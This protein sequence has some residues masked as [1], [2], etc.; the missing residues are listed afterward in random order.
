M[1]QIDLD[2]L[3]SRIYVNEIRAQS[4]ATVA[5]ADAT[6][7]NITVVNLK[8]DVTVPA[9]N[10]ITVEDAAGLAIAGEPL[11]DVVATTSKHWEDKSAAF[12]AVAGTSYICD[13]TSSAF[14]VTLPLEPT[15]GD[16]I[17][18]L[19]A[20]GTFDSNNLTLLGNGEKI[21]RVAS[22]DMAIDED[23]TYLEMI[24]TGTTNGWLVGSTN[25]VL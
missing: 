15:Y 25:L 17:A 9:G 8:G 18:F 1:A 13:T 6:F 2:G 5:V 11:L 19:D 20:G 3:N 22:Q 16:T 4:V 10:T 24:Y 14:S 23:D 7:T 21:M 12:T